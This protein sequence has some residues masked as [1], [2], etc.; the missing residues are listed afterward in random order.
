[1]IENGN[2]D[3]SAP[4]P[5]LVALWSEASLQIAEFDPALAMRL[6]EKAEDRSDP[7]TWDDQKIIAAGI[8]IDAVAS[9]ARSLLQLAIPQPPT[10]RSELAVATAS[11]SDAFLSHASEDKDTV[12]TPLA[13]EL[14]K[15]RYIIW[16]DKFELVVGDQLS[17]ELDRGLGRCRFGVVILSKHF[18]AKEW[19]RME[20]AGLLALETSDGRKRILP[21]RHGLSHAEVVAFSPLLGGR[22][23][24][25]T[26]SGIPIVADV[27]A[28]AMRKQAA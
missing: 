27:L 20:L 25:S 21:V 24:I 2:A 16:Y 14:T 4:N 11:E 17:V 3:E 19:P 7:Q 18:L 9:D 28:A 1:M 26:E 10:P 6:R 22:V 8:G 12:V 13:E 15:R 23:S 5:E